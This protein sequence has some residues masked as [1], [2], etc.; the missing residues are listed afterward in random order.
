MDGQVYTGGGAKP[1][2]VG[3]MMMTMMTRSGHCR[4]G[5]TGNWTT[6]TTTTTTLACGHADV[7]VF[8][9]SGIFFNYRAIWIGALFF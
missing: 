5:E 4:M 7:G 1:P 6:T 2:W 8:E 3:M 9:M